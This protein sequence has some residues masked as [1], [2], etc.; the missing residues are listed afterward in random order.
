MLEQLHYKLCGTH[1]FSKAENL[2]LFSVTVSYL[3]AGGGHCCS[4]AFALER[5]IV[6]T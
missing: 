5:R 3:V 2:A 1:Q 4:T 6:S